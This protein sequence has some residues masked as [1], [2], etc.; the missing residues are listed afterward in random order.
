MTKPKPK[1]QCDI[2]QTDD[3]RHL[4]DKV[5]WD[6]RKVVRCLHSW[7]CRLRALEVLAA[8]KDRAR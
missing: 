1:R 7:E 2:C 4:T 5:T 6:G 8:E 3:Q